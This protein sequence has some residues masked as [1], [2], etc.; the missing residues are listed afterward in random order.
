MQCQ[1]EE[2]ARLSNEGELHEVDHIIPL[3]SETVCGLHVPWNLRAT[4]MVSNRSKAN[5]LPPSS[6]WLAPTDWNRSVVYPIEF[7]NDNTLLWF[8]AA[9]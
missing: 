2:A 5:R 7:D 8:A 1:F 4:D 6:D 3:I 9:V